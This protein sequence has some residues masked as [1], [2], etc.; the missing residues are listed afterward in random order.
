MMPEPAPAPLGKPSSTTTQMERAI[1][2]L[3]RGGVIASTTTILVGTALMFVRHPSYLTSTAELQ[4]LT[5]PGAAFPHTAAEIATGVSACHGQAVIALGLLLLIATPIMRVALSVYA[6]A[7]QGDR[8][9]MVVSLVVLVTL[10]ISFLLG[11]VG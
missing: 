11:K 4:R 5:S 8:F 9:F 2:L 6:F 7:K 10:L 3:L 1:S